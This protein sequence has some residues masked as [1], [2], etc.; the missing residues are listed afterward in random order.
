MSCYRSW[1][2]CSI[3]MQA[4]KRKLAPLLNL[5]YRKEKPRL[6]FVDFNFRINGEIL[7]VKYMH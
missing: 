3:G 1:S 4:F 6:I 7:T 2:D 5:V